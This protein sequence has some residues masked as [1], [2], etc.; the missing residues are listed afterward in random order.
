MSQLVDLAQVYN[1]G[2]SLIRHAGGSMRIYYL[3]IRVGV[4][5]AFSSQNTSLSFLAST[6]F[7]LASTQIMM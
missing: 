2:R 3:Q 6:F 1:L 4:Q 5:A 7:E